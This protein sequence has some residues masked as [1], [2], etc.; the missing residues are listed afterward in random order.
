[1][2]TRAWRKWGLPTIGL[3]TAS[4]ATGCNSPNVA[5]TGSQPSSAKATS[6][7]TTLAPNNSPV[8]PGSSLHGRPAPN[9]TLT[10]QF[11]KPVSLKQYRGK[12]VVLAFVDSECTTICPL[13]TQSMMDAVK[14]LGP[15]AAKDVQLLGIDANPTATTVA[16]VKN[17]SQVHGMTHSWH[18][19][20]GSLAQL[21]QI[22]QDY[23]I[24]A[25][26]VNGQIDHT[27]A[28]YIIDAKGHE[29]FLYLT[30][31][32]Y[33]AV[34]AQASVLAQ[35]IARFLPSAVRPKIRGVQYQA[36][37][38]TNRKIELP[39]QNGTT[40]TSTSGSSSGKVA[41]GPG[42][43]Q[44]LAFYASWVPRLQQDLRQLNKYAQTPNHPQIIGVDVGSTEPSPTAIL[45]TLQK[46]GSLK[47]P[48][49]FDAS[50]NVADTYKVQ[51]LPWLA[52]TN[53][54]GSIIWSHDGMLPANTLQKDVEKA[55]QHV[56]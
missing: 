39:T 4:I 17:Y 50:G 10:D 32:Q 31:S 1:M 26:V 38:G 21:K 19:L 2:K 27:P 8:D 22:W 33:G 52:L 12:V 54:K 28:L 9:F 29:Q 37:L 30:P 49:A 34:S 35:D 48:L 23:Y 53:G 13:T 44:L 11:G 42:K 40:S 56:H 55:L 18:F 7:Q 3:L 15:A 47:F 6:A 43:P 45:P 16:D 24:Y 51:D 41:V 36:P 25:G 20:T 5:Q 46:V 14:Q